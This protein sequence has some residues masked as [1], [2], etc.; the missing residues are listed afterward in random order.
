MKIVKN[1]HNFPPYIIQKYTSDKLTN[2]SLIYDGCDLILVQKI[3]SLIS[4][5]LDNDATII[6]IVMGGHH[7]RYPLPYPLPGFFPTTLPEPYPN[8]NCPTRHSLPLNMGL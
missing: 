8:S 5:L 3:L 7:S 4:K 6:K 1:F 2:T